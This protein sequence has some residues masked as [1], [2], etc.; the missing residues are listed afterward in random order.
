MKVQQANLINRKRKGS[1]S[2]MEGIWRISYYGKELM[3]E[4]GKRNL[5]IR[6]KNIPPI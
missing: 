4:H 6:K 2:S 5:G 1:I 3:L